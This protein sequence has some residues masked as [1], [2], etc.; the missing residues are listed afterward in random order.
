MF[1]FNKIDKQPVNRKQALERGWEIDDTILTTE[2]ENEIVGADCLVCGN[3]SISWI[4]EKCQ[5]DRK[6]CP[7]FKSM[8]D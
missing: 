2:N 3:F 5:C 6:E 7:H 1:N 4:T 8:G